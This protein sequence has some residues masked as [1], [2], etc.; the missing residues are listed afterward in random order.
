MEVWGTHCREWAAVYSVRCTW[1]AALVSVQ[2]QAIITLSVVVDVVQGI[3]QYGGY[4]FGTAILDWLHL[5][6][7]GQCV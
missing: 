4:N 1:N 2:C 7:V 5:V 6:P 3:D